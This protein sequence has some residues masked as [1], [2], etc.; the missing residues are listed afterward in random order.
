MQNSFLK[1]LKTCTWHEEID[2]FYVDAATT[3]NFYIH[4]EFGYKTVSYKMRFL[5]KI[6]IQ[7]H[8]N[9]FPLKM[10]KRIHGSPPLDKRRH[11]GNK[12]IGGK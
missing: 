7:A 12:F 5:N 10:F 8:G 4:T 9:Y 2:R 6:E 11:F 1:V 3:R